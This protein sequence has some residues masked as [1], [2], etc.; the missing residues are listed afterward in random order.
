MPEI[1]DPIDTR[2]AEHGFWGHAGPYLY[3]PLIHVPLI[4]HLP[5]QSHG[6]RIGNPVSNVDIA[7]TVLELLGQE[8]PAWMDGQSFK[9]ALAKGNFESKVK[10]AMK[11]SYEDCWPEFKSR[12]IAAIKGNYELIKYLDFNRYE[13]YDVKNDII[14]H[15]NLTIQEKE[16]F[17]SLQKKLE[18]VLA[19]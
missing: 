10:F 3:E 15:N 19:K 18:Q 17:S 6:V 12:S 16:I 11:F 5:G 8:P 14:L 4:V 7:P 9:P 2:K 13:R 1:G